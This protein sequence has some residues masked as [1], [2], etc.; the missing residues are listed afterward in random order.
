NGHRE[1]SLAGGAARR[2]H[3]STGGPAAL[4]LDLCVDSGGWPRCRDCS[5]D[6]RRQRAVGPGLHSITD[7]VHLRQRFQHA[8]ALAQ[9][10]SAIGLSWITSRNDKTL[11]KK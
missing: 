6:G 10:L 5:T 4:D 8:L 11:E 3:C 7:H 2:L 9:R 1:L